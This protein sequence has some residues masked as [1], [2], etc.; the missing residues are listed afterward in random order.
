MEVMTKGKIEKGG[1]QPL[2]VFEGD[3]G[4]QNFVYSISTSA[5]FKRVMKIT[6]EVFELKEVNFGNIQNPDFRKT[7]VA[8]SPVFSCE[9]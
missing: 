7:W 2:L 8:A 3:Y 5:D 4:G 1:I 6:Q 9:R